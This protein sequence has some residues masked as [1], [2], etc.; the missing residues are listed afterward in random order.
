MSADDV[1]T[2][3]GYSMWEVHRMALSRRLEYRGWAKT[4]VYQLT[5]FYYVQMIPN[6][7]RRNKEK[8]M[9]NKWHLYILLL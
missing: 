5:C 7:K 1:R 4:S 2:G 6:I 9:V 3:Q 8:F